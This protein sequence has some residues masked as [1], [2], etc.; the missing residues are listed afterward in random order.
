M[1]GENK[2]RQFRSEM[3]LTM[4]S[5]LLSE[6]KKGVKSTRQKCISVGC[7]TLKS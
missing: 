3:T 7:E 6:A 4:S 1:W 2:A 5:N